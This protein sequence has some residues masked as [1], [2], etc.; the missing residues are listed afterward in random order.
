MQNIKTFFSMFGKLVSILNHK[1][2]RQG[3]IL[4]F[5]LIITSVLEMLGVSVIVPF[6]ITMLQPQEIMQNQYIA[7]I[8]EKFH[9]TNYRNFMY[10]LSAGVVFIYVMKNGFILFVNYYQSNYRNQLEKDLNIKMLNSYMKKPYGFFVNVN[11][12]EIIRGVNG[13]MANIAT[14]VDGYS[15][16]FAEGLTCTIIGVFLVCMNPFMAISLVLVAGGT[17]IGIILIFKS[18]TGRSGEQC[19]EAF[20]EKFKHI[21]QAIS[22]IKEITVTQHRDFFVDKYANAAQKAAINNTKYLWISKAPTRLIETVFIGCLLLVVTISYNGAS[23]NLEFVTQL[24]AI[25]IAAVRILPS[26]ST[27]TNAMNSLVFVRPSLE[28]AYENLKESEKHILSINENEIQKAIFDSKID[29]KNISFKYQEDLPYVLKDLNMTIQKGESIAFIG[30]SGAGKSTL[31]DILLGLY[32]P[33]QGRVL[34]D[35]TDIFTMQKSWSKMIGYV[36]QMVFLLDDT[37]RNNIAFGVK[38][39]EINDEKVWYA[40]EQAQL[41]T[42]VEDMELRL[43]TVVGEK[44]IKLSGGQ[45]QRIAIARA[46]YH[47]PDI[48]IMDEATSALDSETE[49]AVMEAIDSLHGKKT[50][51]IIAHRLTTIKNCDKIF[52]IKNRM[53]V[54]REKK[55]LFNE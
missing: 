18:K 38:Q 26:V 20:A 21:N 37:I 23:N 43:D 32:R 50:L 27:L 45:R 52:E 4:F 19:R 42:V 39:E 28:A 11:S 12:A 5:L 36:P 31:A 8:V 14:V 16:I 48:L 35:G 44:G 7:P 9:I 46:L 2:K 17:A 13:D 24:G 51:I 1:Q 41:K 40:L 25:G 34:V 29:I 6:I 15:S 47:N 55:E 3:I 22:G 54:L 33:E 49:S 30:E 53:A 10:L